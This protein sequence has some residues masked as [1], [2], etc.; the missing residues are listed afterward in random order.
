MRTV[1][2]AQSPGLL[3]F[4]AIIP[5]LGVLISF[6]IMIWM[7]V[8]W[9]IAIRQALEA[10]DGDSLFTAL[11]KNGEIQLEVDGETLVFTRAEVEVKI[12]EK[13]GM[14]TAADSDILV[15][16][17]TQLTP[18]LIAEGWA[19]EVVASAGLQRLA[20]G[21]PGMSFET[22]ERGRFRDG[23]GRMCVHGTEARPRARPT[24]GRRSAP[25]AWQ[26][27]ATS[28]RR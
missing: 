19:R 24:P 1:G 17:D 13:E 12:H 23:G 16:L 15:A 9:V 28:T 18:E 14:A 2:F 5:I 25:T 11:E 10:A 6:V 22:F 4:V 3:S 21:A 7:I 26:R 20:R 27:G 8:A